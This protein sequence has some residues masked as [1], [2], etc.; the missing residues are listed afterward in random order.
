MKIYEIMQELE[1]IENLINENTI[2]DKETGEFT[3]KDENILNE[4]KTQ[5]QNDFD[6]KLLSYRHIIK[7]LENNNELI[8]N[9]ISLYQNKIKK[10]E[11][12]IS[13]LKD[14]ISFIFE[15]LDINSKEY[16]T[17]EKISFTTRKNYEYNEKELEKLGY[18][19]E[20]I[21]INLD[22]EKAKQDFKTGKLTI[23]IKEYTQ[24]YLNI[25]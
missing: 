15:K 19:R 14:T 20:K 3:I 12:I 22:K 24:K 25:K 1:T 7:N 23:G 10:N 5:L 6:N 17:G 21:E 9:E 11:N 8:K 18:I 13:K 16:P 4:L 2:I